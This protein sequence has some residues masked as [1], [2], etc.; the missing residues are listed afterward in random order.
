MSKSNL[1]DEVAALQA[2]AERYRW[3]RSQAG[4][5][6]RDD[7]WWGYWTLPMLDGWNHTP[8]A[9]KRGEAFDHKTLDEAIDAA[10]KKENGD[11]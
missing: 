10:R 9:E 5:E 6:G 8:Y 7:G 11:G 3:L 1:V 2:D 4:R